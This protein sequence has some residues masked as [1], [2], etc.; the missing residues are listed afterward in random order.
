MKLE[1]MDAMK[2]EV[3]LLQI[4]SSLYKFSVSRSSYFLEIC[5]SFLSCYTSVR[6]N[7]YKKVE[8]S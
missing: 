5:K 7:L 4:S 3:I 1:E 6:T 2:K 8:D